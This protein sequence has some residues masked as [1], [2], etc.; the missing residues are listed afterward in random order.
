VVLEAD[1]LAQL[2]VKVSLVGHG[3]RCVVPD[4]PQVLVVARLQQVGRDALAQLAARCVGVCALIQPRAEQ[5]RGP[6]GALRED[7]ALGQ[8]REQLLDQRC[9]VSVALMR[10]L[11]GHWKA[12]S[13]DPNRHG[14]IRGVF[15]V[16]TPKRVEQRFDAAPQPVEL[17]SRQTKGV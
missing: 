2:G 6:R 5:L 7:V 11:R 8:L 13:E 16:G 9:R 1:L 14:V 15:A 17:G 4:E 10:V 3:R 12:E